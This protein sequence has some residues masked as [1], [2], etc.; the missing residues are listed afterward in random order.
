MSEPTLRAGVVELAERLQQAGRWAEA[1]SMLRNELRTHDGDAALHRALAILRSRTRRLDEAIVSM[2]QATRM[3]PNE[4]AWWCELGRMLASAQRHEEAIA[5]FVRASEDAP[6]WVEPWFFLG[7]TYQRAGDVARAL[8]A[9][10]RAQALAAHDRRVLE[11]LARLEFE[12]GEPEDALPLWEKLCSAEPTRSEFWLRRGECLTR[13]GR[14]ADARAV[15]SSALREMPDSADLSLGLA[16]AEEDAGDKR[17][18]E[19][20]YRRALGI[21]PNWAPALGG[22]LDMLRDKADDALV[23]SGLALQSDPGLQDAD[24]ATLGYGLGKVFDRR[25]DYARAIACW[26]DANAAR[27]R[28]AGVFDRPAMQ[29]WLEHTI[30]TYSRRNLPTSGHAFADEALPVFVIGMPRSGTTLVEQIIAAHPHA[31]GCGELPDIARHALMLQPA[32]SD[33]MH[34][35]SSSAAL[36]RSFADCAAHYLAK[37]RRIGGPVQRAVDKLPL[38]FFHLGLIERLFPSARIVWCRRDR[39]DIALSIYSENFALDSQFATDIDDI[40]WLHDLHI[41]IMQRWQNALELRV[42]EVEYES[43]VADPETHIRGLIDFIGLPWDDA[44]LAFHQLER[45][46]Q[47]PSRW[48][49]RQ[50]IHAG[51]VGRWRRYAQL[52]EP[53][54]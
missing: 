50:P 23:A 33:F 37:L 32:L 15:F 28:H 34:D 30:R 17:A 9:L 7:V 26:R 27:R 39:R 40:L 5:A 21:R 29:R 53:S 2:Q 54:T 45:N 11:A 4:P 18:A 51:S 13:A 46:V 44:C 48:Q 8:P 16:Q 25:G 24:R 20:A 14:H 52:F 31:A 22:L 10:R 41:E 47:T 43:L 35:A 3:R 38:N 12:A 19:H 1:E 36:A 42:H 6:D 49:V